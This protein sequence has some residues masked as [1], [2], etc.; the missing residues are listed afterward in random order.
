MTKKKSKKRK[1]RNSSG[2]DSEV[3]GDC[4]QP[5]QRGPSGDCNV[6][7]SD[8]LNKTNSVLYGDNSTVAD[9]VFDSSACCDSV[10]NEE[11]GCNSCEDKSVA[12]MAES[13]ARKEPTNRDIMDC[14]QA[15]G[16]RI[17][18]VEQ[19]LKS[20]E[21]LD[22][23]MVDFDKELRGIRTMMNDQAKM[24]NERVNKLEDK[25]DGT[26]INVAMM[27][28]RVE[29][30]EK[31]RDGLK[32][33]VAY[34]KSQSMRNNLVFTGVPEVGGNESYEQTEAKL[35]Q[36]LVE[37]MKLAQETVNSIKFERVHRSPSEPQPGRIRSIVAKFTYFKVRETV[38]KQWKSLSGTP[39]NVFEQ[40]PPEVV[41]KRKKLAP[42]MK[43][44][45]RQGK[46]SYI[47]YDT[48][49]V[50]GKAVKAE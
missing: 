9:S 41:A 11:S 2:T 50:D 46:R 32:D 22:K 28:S 17:D 47:V 3:V 36:H 19:K 48:L 45:R 20:I 13:D 49:Y 18:T 25:V 10:M 8:I 21:E 6:S 26:D 42:K 4:K 15:I 24:I 31:E 44:A 35:R 14:L 1:Y 27:T 5:K 39:Y 16:K 29:E 33:D 23:K 40:F 34:L 30:L 12:D 37:A 43:E 38:R 7:V